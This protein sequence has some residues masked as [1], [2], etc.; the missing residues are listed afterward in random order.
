MLIHITPRIFG[1]RDF[2]PCQ[3]VDL[4]CAELGL[5]LKANVELMAR[6][7]YPNKNYLVACRKRGQKAMQGFLIERPD[8]VRE[9]T[10]VTRWAVAA[11]HVATHRVRYIVLDDDYDTISDN[12]VLW[13][14][15]SDG[16]GGWESR[17]PKQY[18]DIAP[19]S[20]QPTMEVTPRMKHRRE[21]V[22]VINDDGFLVERN[23]TLYL[24]TLE[25]ARVINMENSL[26]ERIAG[27]DAVF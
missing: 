10:V 11:W 27:I 3:L 15:M 24:P 7:P 19:V 4:N 2:E 21:C 17:W 13:Y 20:L 6:R 14:G 12:I 25:R 1:N 9:F 23:E 5:A 16:L 8:P 26:G 18:E 22:D